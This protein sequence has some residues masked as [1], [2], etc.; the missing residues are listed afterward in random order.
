[1]QPEVLRAQQFALARHLRDPAAHAPPPGVEERRLR[2]YRELF[3][4]NVESLLGNSFPVISATLGPS[5]WKALARTFYASHRS[6]T[7]LFPQ[8]AGEF[9][10]YLDAQPDEAGL[11][12]WLAEMA[13]YEWVE[14]ALFTSDAQ[15]PGHDRE[16]DLLE[17]VP[18]LSPLAKPLIYRWPVPEIGPS[19]VPD[20]PADTPTMMLVHRGDD[21]QVN[22]TRLAPLAFYL[23]VSVQDV[24][25]T[26]RDHLTALAEET[27]ADPATMQA[28]GLQLLTL[29]R[30]QGVILGTRD[31]TGAK[32]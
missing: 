26:G 7:P 1:M 5:R 17:G 22:F 13:H 28:H 20:A 31:D 23:L 9:V 15:P 12:P 25:R 8:L 10:A 27:G 2:V 3:F 24:Q 32:P 14:Q 11:P 21:H 4:N 19:H 29:L 18:L 16:G 30:E 6:R